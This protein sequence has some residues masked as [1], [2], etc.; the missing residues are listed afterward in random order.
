ME[1]RCRKVRT[2]GEYLQFT[3]EAEE[4]KEKTAHRQKEEE[5][6]P[7]R[8]AMERS[9]KKCHEG[10]QENFWPLRGKNPVSLD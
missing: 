2:S 1:K 5:L 7:F 3:K 9:G 6:G 4:W 8:I 10:S